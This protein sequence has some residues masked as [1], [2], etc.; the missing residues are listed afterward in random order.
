M[1]LHH[2]TITFERS[3]IVP[4]ARMFGAYAD[5]RQREVWSAP[6]PT[7][8]VRIDT[9]DLRTGGRETA[10]CGSKDDLR[11]SLNVLYHNVVPDRLITFTE[12]LWEGDQ[13]LTV[14]L[15]T[16][17]FAPSGTGTRLTLT[18]QV[19]SFVGKEAISGHRQGYTAALA[20]LAAH[21]LS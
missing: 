19:T 16:F 18:D 3:F 8:A 14:A 21:V 4:P 12:E 13:I 2:D 7:A 10:R 6:S 1:D 9:C 11:W 20:N 5:P 17:D 15:I